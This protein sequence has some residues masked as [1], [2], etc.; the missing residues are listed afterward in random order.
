[1][2]KFV[3]ALTEPLYVKKWPVHIHFSEFFAQTAW[4]ES[5]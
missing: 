3:C 5:I 2:F 1:M 4:S